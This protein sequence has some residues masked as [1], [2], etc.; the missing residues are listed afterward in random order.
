MPLA[1][2]RLL[3]PLVAALLLAAAGPAGA[4]QFTRKNEIGIGAGG[5]FAVAF[6]PDSKLLAIGGGTEAAPALRVWDV[7]AVKFVAHLKGHTSAVWTVAFSKDGKRLASG[8]YDATARVWDLASGREVARVA[9]FSDR[10][11]GVA[12]SPDGKLLAA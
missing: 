4:A 10:V 5:P 1:S 11:T 3:L 6:S 2:T 9:A 12:F 8:G 7:E